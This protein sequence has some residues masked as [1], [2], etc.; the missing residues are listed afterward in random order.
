MLFRS[1]S[2]LQE[3]LAGT[4]PFDPGDFPGPLRLTVSLQGNELRFPTKKDRVYRIEQHGP[5]GS[6][7]WSPSAALPV[8]GTGAEATV[9]LDANPADLFFYRLVV[10]PPLTQL[11]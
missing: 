5:F 10:Y 3:Y 9:H 11:N 6:G 2:D 7:I 4:D 8:V 1:K